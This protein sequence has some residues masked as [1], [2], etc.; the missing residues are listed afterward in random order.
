MSNL[1]PIDEMK[2]SKQASKQASKGSP[3]EDNVHIRKAHN[4]LDKA[5]LQLDYSEVRDE[6]AGVVG[7]L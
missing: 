1:V 2:A 4:T 6:R 5:L 3:G 7:N